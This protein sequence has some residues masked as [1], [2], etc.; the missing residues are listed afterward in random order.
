[1][2]VMDE[3]GGTRVQAVPQDLRT[4]PS[5]QPSIVRELA[6]CALRIEQHYGKP[7]DI[8]WAVDRQ[9][10][11][12]LLQTR[13]LHVLSDA[14]ASD[15]P[16]SIPVEIAPES[17][18]VEGGT[19][20]CPGAGAGPVVQVTS[21]H[22]LAAV[23]KGAVVVAPN[24]F[25]GLITVMGKATALVT[26]VGGVAS[27]MATLAREYRIPTLVGAPGAIALQPGMTVTVDA[28]AGRILDGIHAPLVAARRRQAAHIF[29]DMP[30]FRGFRDILELVAPLNLL[31]PSDPGFTPANCKTLHDIT[32]FAHQCAMS[33]IFGRVTDLESRATVGL[34]LESSLPLPVLL[35]YVDR[36]MSGLGRNGRILDTEVDSIPFRALWEGMLQQGWPSGPTREGHEF[37]PALV[38]HGGE[39]TTEGYSVKSFAVLART[40]M[41]LS[42]HLGYHFTT[43]EAMADDEPSKNY[44]RLQYKDG[45]AS[46]ER[47]VRRIRLVASLLARLGFENASQADF[48]DASV[49]Y[50]DAAQVV[51]KM[52]VLGRIVLLTKQLDMALSNDRITEWYTRD[53]AKRL[54]L[55]AEV[56]P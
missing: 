50:E 23:P 20:A 41:M 29:E 28:T 13:P 2:L 40:Y 12:F 37:Q 49:S 53:F 5:I 15:P 10:K 9:G 18:L 48:L 19:T 52:A 6:Q 38:T 7:Q 55:D 27:H 31:H 4:Q 56:T 47:R 21:S 36:P 42:L 17:V 32:R 39:R 22:D 35:L 14:R 11:V 54:G 34:R 44:I 33:E 46:L 51:R 1:M 16:S 45:G 8:E 26:E 3:L 43:I 25:P 30:L 24:P